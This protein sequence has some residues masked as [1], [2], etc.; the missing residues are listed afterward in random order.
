[1]KIHSYIVTYQHGHPQKFSQGRGLF[2]G[3]LARSAYRTVALEKL[4]KCRK[5]REFS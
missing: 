4:N 2:I 1:M 5:D 3:Y